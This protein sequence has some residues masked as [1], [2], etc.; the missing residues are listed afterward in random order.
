MTTP[1][2]RQQRA[3]RTLS[4]TE[5]RAGE[6]WLVPPM[7]FGDLVAK[8]RDDGTHSPTYASPGILIAP[9]CQSE[10]TPEHSGR[11]TQFRWICIDETQCLGLAGYSDGIVLLHHFSTDA[12]SSTIKIKEVDHINDGRA[13]GNVNSSVLGAVTQIVTWAQRSDGKAWH[14][15]V[16]FVTLHGTTGTIVLWEVSQCSMMR[17]ASKWSL[18]RNSGGLSAGA[19]VPHAFGAGA[20]GMMGLGRSQCLIVGTNEG[21][22]FCVEYAVT[23][24]DPS[25][26]Q[27]AMPP[28]QIYK[29]PDED[30]VTS[31]S[32]S[33]DGRFL[34]TG[35]QSNPWSLFTLK[36]Q[37]R[38]GV[39]EM[40]DSSV[41]AVG[42]DRNVALTS[43]WL[44]TRTLVVA[45]A[46]GKILACHPVTGDLSLVTAL[47]VKSKLTRAS[48]TFCGSKD[49]VV[50]CL[51][52]VFIVLITAVP[53][54]RASVLAD[55]RKGPNTSSTRLD[56]S[57]GYH[58]RTAIQTEGGRPSNMYDGQLVV[59][60]SG[61]G[62]IDYIT[63]RTSPAVSPGKAQLMGE[64]GKGT[65]L[66][67]I[68]GNI[69]AFDVDGSLL[70]K[71]TDM[72][73]CQIL[74]ANANKV[75][76]VDWCGRLHCYGGGTSLA[77]VIEAKNHLWTLGG[78]EA[79]ELS[80][81][82]RQQ[83]QAGPVTGVA[84]TDDGAVVFCNS[85]GLFVVD[86]SDASLLV[87]L[88]ISKTDGKPTA[89]DLSGDLLAVALSTGKVKVWKLKG[90]MGK[91]PIALT[92]ARDIVSDISSVAS[93]IVGVRIKHKG[94]VVLLEC[95]RDDRDHIKAGT[96]NVN[97]GVQSPTVLFVWDV[98][99][100]IVVPVRLGRADSA[101]VIVNYCWETAD[102]DLFAV[103]SICEAEPGRLCFD[104][105]YYTS[106]FGVVT[107]ERFMLA[108]PRAGAKA[109]DGTDTSVGT[110]G[111]SQS[112]TQRQTQHRGQCQTT[113]TGSELVLIAV[114]APY[115]YLLAISP[116]G[117]VARLTRRTMREFTTG[118]SPGNGNEM[119]IHLNP[120]L[121]SVLRHFTRALCNADDD[122]ALRVLHQ[123][124]VVQQTTLENNENST[125]SLLSIAVRIAVQLRSIDVAL[126]CL[127]G[128]N[129]AVAAQHARQTLETYGDD[130]IGLGVVCMHLGMN[131][132]ALRYFE[133][134]KDRNHGLH[135]AL[136]SA[137]WNGA[138]RQ[139]M[140]SPHAGTMSATDAHY[141]HFAMG[142]HL[143]YMGNEPVAITAFERGLSHRT[144]VVRMP[145]SEPHQLER[146]CLTEATD[147]SMARWWQSYRE[148]EGLLEP[149]KE[150]VNPRQA[151]ALGD[152]DPATLV[153][154]YCRRGE[155]AASAE[156]AEIASVGTAWLAYA[157]ECES[158]ARHRDAFD[159]Y[160]RA[161]SPALALRIAVAQE[162]TQ[163]V[164]TL[165]KTHF[166]HAA[167]NG[168][169]QG[170]GTRRDVDVGHVGHAT[171]AATAANFLRSRGLEAEAKELIAMIVGS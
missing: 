167:K 165:A 141:V 59:I 129:Y 137:D 24:S 147:G 53:W 38:E 106:E 1:F 4:L 74:A 112:S 104:L 114:A 57:V 97:H 80:G 73:A 48:V 43:M 149:Q 13:D 152:T 44:N 72:P 116:T 100:D 52:S 42:D 27:P 35:W 77:A 30:G 75:C 84:V 166:G 29:D 145:M 7:I 156:V 78:P 113:T 31:L 76:V 144:E 150:H 105:L 168:N 12:E 65:F 50:L 154:A 92:V 19:L 17:I 40:A 142:R 66:C 160:L 33:G 140:A 26:V 49:E 70:T 22:L 82:W 111:Q 93:A 85:A 117:T 55:P 6:Q 135:L 89:L 159:A 46:S 115:V 90:V 32:I 11:L 125:S 41:F 63:P 163:E 164:Y 54:V 122:D 124:K 134:S 58:T 16:A 146:Y 5:A 91:T 139:T 79:P 68:H 36:R 61:L 151:V 64:S 103:Q 138:V 107:K 155:F 126:Y 132:L 45:L 14:Q 108:S 118:G 109:N 95:V 88:E 69:S 121:L 169:G 47:P 81:K 136:A 18:P 102:S 2:D 119:K 153:R 131:D 128:L 23:E 20:S 9:K 37:G 94:A 34:C 51:G 8:V 21:S 71:A 83:A 161:G 127:G 171:Q 28:Q 133:E 67:G 60:N 87:E 99:S 98:E 62:A 3:T 120:A 158:T 56:H 25:D 10:F 101:S 39:E 170:R 157:A 162:W 86:S 123:Y 130:L 15:A 148:S 143:E 96:A 110:A